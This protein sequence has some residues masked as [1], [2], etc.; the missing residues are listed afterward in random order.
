MTAKFDLALFIGLFA[1]AFPLS[2]RGG[3]LFGG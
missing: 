2:E 3:F 1:V